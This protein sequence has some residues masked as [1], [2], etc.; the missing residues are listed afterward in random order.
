MKLPLL[1]K[2]KDQNEL[3]QI[4]M[5]INK[6]G[7]ESLS[8]ILEKQNKTLLSI[9]DTMKKQYE[10]SLIFNR[11]QREREIEARNNSNPAG[12]P[13]DSSSSDN[14]GGSGG[15]GGGS[16]GFGK[17]LL[18]IGLAL[19]G[20]AFGLAA[21][22]NPATAIGGG[23]LLAFLGGLAGVGWLAGQAAQE[24]GKG[25]KEISSGIDALD[26]TGKKV[27][28]DN[29]VAA[30]EGLTAFL[31]N[32]G[33]LKGIFG[34]VI[35][36]LTGDLVNIAD[37]MNKLNTINVDK[38][39]LIA[40]GEG[41]N[42]FMSAMGEGSFFDKLL[43]SI[44]TAIA[45]DMEK[46]ASGVSKLSDVSK[47]FDLAK[48]N[49]MSAGMAAI[50][51]P[52]A[53]FGKSGIV[54][55]FVGDEALSDIASGI[56]ALNNTQ[57]DRLE[58]VAKGIKFL[59]NDLWEIVKTAFAANFVGENAL[60]DIGDGIS[61]LNKTEVDRLETV[62]AG[63]ETIKTPLLN[64]T[65]IG[66]AANFVGKN[67]LIDIADGIDSLNNTQVD[68]LET[69]GAGLETI[70]TPLLNFTG[71]GLAANFVGKNAIIDIADGAKD[72]M[73]KIGTDEKV[74]QA[75]NVAKSLNNMREALSSFTTSQVWN[76]LASVGTK[77]IGFLGGDENPIDA[78]LSLSNEADN[79]SKTA[80]ALEKISKALNS[81]SGISFNTDNMD[82]EKLAKNL[83]NTIPLLDKLANGGVSKKIFGANIDFGKGILD[84][85]LKLDQVA[86]MIKKVRV[87]LGFE[88]TK[89]TNVSNGT[90]NTSTNVSNGTNN[91]STNVS[92]GTNNTSTN[93]SNGTNN[94]STN[95]SNGT[96]NTSTNVSDKIA[97]ISKVVFNG[98]PISEFIINGSISK[99]LY[100]TLTRN[101]EAIYAGSNEVNKSQN[102]TT[103]IAPQISD[104]S[105]KT[106]NTMSGGGGGK[107][108]TNVRALDES[109]RD[110][111]TNPYM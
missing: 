86:E 71:I 50:A 111:I 52:L 63:L 48:F 108:S 22:A 105:V 18:G 83:G 66:L 31:E 44:S 54:A 60:T 96:N 56:T 20:L 24:I 19:K 68:R 46:L 101:G 61:Y 104:N 8:S 4:S 97:E 5:E 21:F 9:K 51:A 62:G 89:A 77:I 27:E 82:F 40:A 29:L 11:E 13:G 93:V 58:T 30:G 67:A 80:T 17:G 107:S 109:V 74:K 12:L 16:G 59:D 33:S 3:I 41:L 81:F 26:E 1:K 32:V 47:T 36:F 88:D 99:I 37:G 103:I 78:I 43:G 25:F 70:K 45:P 79:L 73:E 28:M 72:I 14:A 2:D 42:G 34:A 38:E 87:V 69:V 95:V 91:T 98:G 49:D 85:N 53:E 39:K 35:T 6:V 94:T 110:F 55:N 90:N 15:S 102:G 57:V 106:N 92:N 65:G 10:N 7:F 84:P 23:V 100:G 76:T 75:E 64:F